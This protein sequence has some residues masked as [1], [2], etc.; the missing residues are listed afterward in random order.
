MPALMPSHWPDSARGLLVALP[1]LLFPFSRL[2]TAGLILLVLVTAW[3]CWRQPPRCWPPPPPFRPLL[4]GLLAIGGPVLLTCLAKPL[5]GAGF[6]LLWLRKLSTI[7]VAALFAL[8]TAQQLS[9]SPQVRRVALALIA[10][11]VSFW[12][13]DG[14]VQFG[15]G[16]DLFGIP[17]ADRGPEP[18]RVGIFFANPLTFGYYIPFFSVFPAIWC[19]RARCSWLLSA[20]VLLASGVVTLAAGSRNAMLAYCLLVGMLALVWALELPRIQRLG[21]LLGA[22]LLLVGLTTTIYGLNASFRS[23]LDQTVTVLQAPSPEAL[24][25]ALSYRLEI[26][27][28]AWRLIQLHWLFGLGPGQFRT[29]MRSLLPADSWHARMGLEVH[30]AH[31]V[32]LEIALG[33][34]LIGL[35]AFLAYYG[36][37][38]GWFGRCRRYLHE[39]AG[40]GLAGLL[41]F[42]LLWF[43]LGTQKNFYGSDQLFLSFYFLA[44]GFAV[45]VPGLGSLS[46]QGPT[47]LEELGFLEKCIKGIGEGRNQ[48]SVPG[49]DGSS[50]QQRLDQG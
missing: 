22:P 48:P 46:I 44:I 37:V 42:L 1:V 27:Q 18:P 2:Y 5:L 10:G 8:A 34:G 21:V 30:H 45:L 29:E 12:L 20:S 6:E 25:V 33:T 24:D 16:R 23:R 14:L 7:L 38:A 9:H 50:Q 3:D 17:L 15:F 47:R 11:T 39:P 40:Q 41:V 26:W 36:V 43:P 32:L 13:V 35:L 4:W 28:P 49:E 31:Q 19:L